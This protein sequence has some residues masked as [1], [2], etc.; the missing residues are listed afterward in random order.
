MAEL[1]VLIERDA[2]G[3]V[4]M[5]LNRPGVNNAYNGDMLDALIAGWAGVRAGSNTRVVVLSGNGRHF[6]AGADLSWLDGVR[7]QG[8]QANLEA[9]ERTARAMWELNTLQVPTVALVQGGC[10]GGGTGIAASCDVVIA[11]DNAKFAIAETR[12]GMAATIIFPQLADAIGVR[13]LRRYAQT[14]ERFGAEEARRIGLVHEVVPLA[15]LE[16]AGAKVVDALLRNAPRANAVTKAG[17]LRQAWS[18]VHR[19]HFAA[20]VAEHAAAR[21]SAEAAE[22]LASF[23]G[24]RDA[25]WYPGP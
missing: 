14:G 24:K 10:F 19:S 20:I 11:A 18:E 8:S 7:V 3:V 23:H 2:R 21:Q 12:W 5:F 25:A 15:E 17:V 6:Q 13:H 16:A 9:S 22:G 1:P 4:R